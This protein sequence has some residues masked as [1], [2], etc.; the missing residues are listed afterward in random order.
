M[1]TH[2]PYAS[3]QYVHTISPATQIT[4]GLPG[5]I[6]TTTIINPSPNAPQKEGINF[7]FPG[8]IVFSALQVIMSHFINQINC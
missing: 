6:Q 4:A 8:S 7:S 1:P 2:S 3:Q 5:Q